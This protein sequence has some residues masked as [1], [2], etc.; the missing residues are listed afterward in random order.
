MTLFKITRR[1]KL[2]ARLWH[3]ILTW[4]DGMAMMIQT[5]RGTYIRACLNFI[6]DVFLWLLVIGP[7]G[8]ALSRHSPSVFSH[9][10]FTLDQRYTRLPFL[11]SW[12]RLMSH[13]P[14]LL[15]A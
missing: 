14:K 11:A 3:M 12:R 1:V 7:L 6:P 9:S 5:I 2:R 8:N 10:A 15:S 13:L 4:W